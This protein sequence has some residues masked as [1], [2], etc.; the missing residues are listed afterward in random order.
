M[1]TYI[2]QTAPN[3]SAPGNFAQL[4][5]AYRA[6]HDVSRADLKRAIYGGHAPRRPAI[7]HHAA[8]AATAA[9]ASG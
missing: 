6:K 4:A 3:G 2:P 5:S 1:G 9:A 7:H 8:P